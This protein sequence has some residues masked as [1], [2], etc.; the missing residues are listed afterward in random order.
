[1]PVACMQNTRPTLTA[2]R[3]VIMDYMDDLKKKRNRPLNKNVVIGKSEILHTIQ[4][5]I[6]TL[7][8]PLL[9][10]KEKGWF[11]ENKKMPLPAD[12]KKINKGWYA[13]FHQGGSGV[14]YT[15]E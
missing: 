13:S 4:R 8:S 6:N 7:T 14:M 1:M 5:S 10:D 15:L 11:S 9:A 12:K 3:R 2:V